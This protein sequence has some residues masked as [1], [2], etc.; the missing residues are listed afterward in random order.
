L[1]MFMLVAPEELVVVGVVLADGE[2]VFLDELQAARAR[3][4]ARTSGIKRFTVTFRIVSTVGC[5]GFRP[6]SLS[7]AGPIL[8]RGP[9]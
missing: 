5:Q 2:L 6:A 1:A 9:G 3:A 7:A 8:L 4:A